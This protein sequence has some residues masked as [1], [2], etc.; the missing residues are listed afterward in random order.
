MAVS[1]KDGDGCIQNLLANTFVK[2]G[3]HSVFIYV[4][5]AAVQYIKCGIRKCE[6][7]AARVDF[8][9]AFIPNSYSSSVLSINKTVI[10]VII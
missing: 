8:V 10:M 9:S 4:N 3:H 1:V 5:V 7:T 2:R 6:M